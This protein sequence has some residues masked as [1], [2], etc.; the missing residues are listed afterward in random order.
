[1]TL[2]R[3][4][5]IFFDFLTKETS[6]TSSFVTTACASICKPKYLAVDANGKCHAYTKA[7]TFDGA[8]WI[9]QGRHKV[10]VFTLPAKVKFDASLTLTSLKDL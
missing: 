10:F 5:K 2:A 7:P 3:E 9:E 8:K 6:D 4:I 1:M